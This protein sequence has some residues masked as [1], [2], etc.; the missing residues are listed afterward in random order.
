MKTCQECGTEIKGRA[1]KKFCD[2]S[3]RNTFNNRE[4]KDITNQMRNV[5]R[6]LSKNRKILAEQNPKGK[7]VM[8]KNKLVNLGFSF[9]YFTEIFENKDGRRYYY[10]YDQ[11]Y[12]YI[13]ETQVALVHKT[14][15]GS[16]L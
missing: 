8:A 12:F 13:D 6:A 5:N 15:F 3:C 11:G 9:N 1:D 7:K 4:T 10:V 2:D 14:E 16:R